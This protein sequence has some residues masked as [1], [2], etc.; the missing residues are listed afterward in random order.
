MAKATNKNLELKAEIATLNQQLDQS[1]IIKQTLQLSTL[2]DIQALEVYIK[3]LQN[4]KS[5]QAK[6]DFP[7]LQHWL[8]L[9]HNNFATRLVTR[10]P[11]LSPTELT[12]CYLQRIG[13]SLTQ[14]SIAMEVKEDTIKR[15]IY[16]ASEH[17]KIE[18]DKEKTE[19]TKKFALFVKSF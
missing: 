1:N 8:N 2:E 4:P 3:L 14:M 12:L 15:N 9:A 17:L 11:N 13:Y 10:Y 18:K 6:N 5:Y 16:R 7:H 19:R